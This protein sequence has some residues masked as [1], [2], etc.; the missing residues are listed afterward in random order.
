M[1]WCNDPK[2]GL[3]RQGV[4]HRPHEQIE[5][6]ALIDPC[7]DPRCA[8]NRDGVGHNVTAHAE[9]GRARP[10]A[11]PAAEGGAGRKARPFDWMAEDPEDRPEN[12]AGRRYRDMYGDRTPFDDAFDELGRRIGRDY[13]DEKPGDAGARRAAPGADAGE[14]ESGSFRE[15][16]QSETLSEGARIL[17]SDDP[18]EVLGLPAGASH[19]EVRARYKALVKK[20]DPSRGIITKPAE[21]KALEEQLMVKVHRAYGLLKGR[22]S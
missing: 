9:D 15:A 2:C 20:Y 21:Q 13:G 18:Y 10:D 8:L 11:E 14:A 17:R 1:D 12:K 19:A 7:E 6:E 4:A 16:A 5:R 22:A 3:N